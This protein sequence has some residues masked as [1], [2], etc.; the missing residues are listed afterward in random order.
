M[1]IL[2][3]SHIQTFLLLFRYFSS[4]TQTPTS[5]SAIA[6][7]DKFEPRWLELL[8]LRFEHGYNDRAIALK[9][10][11]TDRTIRN[12]WKRIQ[13]ALNID[14]DPDKDIK[15]QIELK[16]REIGLID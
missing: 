1:N 6:S 8:R 14:D 4:I 2:I 12:Y 11:V 3:R 7:V 10:G 9:M 16:A 5:P 15:V 13:E